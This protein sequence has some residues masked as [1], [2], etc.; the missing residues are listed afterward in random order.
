[1]LRLAYDKEVKVHGE[2]TPYARSMLG[3]LMYFFKMV[4][5]KHSTTLESIAWHRASGAQPGYWN[6][7]QRKKRLHVDN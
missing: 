1:M 3:R 7:T 4:P 6:R 5:Q 2:E